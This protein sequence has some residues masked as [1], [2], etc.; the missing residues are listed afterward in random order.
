M[1]AARVVTRSPTSEA[2]RWERERASGGS[3]VYAG[4]PTLRGLDVPVAVVGPGA[5]DARAPVHPLDTVVQVDRPAP[6]LGWLPPRGQT[7][8]LKALMKHSPEKGKLN[9]L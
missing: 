8:Q 9:C 7:E 3:L 2:S 5:G 6:P 4:V 1:A